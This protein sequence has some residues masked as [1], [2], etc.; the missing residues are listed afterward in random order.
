PQEYHGEDLVFL[1]SPK[2]ELAYFRDR[3]NTHGNYVGAERRNADSKGMTIDGRD[4]MLIQKMAG[5]G[6]AGDHGWMVATTRR[7]LLRGS[8]SNSYNMHMES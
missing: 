7:N 6:R 5:I 3:R 1:C 8:R 4:N 2:T